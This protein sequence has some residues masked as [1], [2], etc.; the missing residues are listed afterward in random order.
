[1]GITST[2]FRCV[3]SRQDW[4]L[5]FLD[6]DL[7]RGLGERVTTG[8]VILA[9]GQMLRIV[10][11]LVN[12]TVMSRLLP[13]ADFGLF[14]MATTVTAFAMLFMDFGLSSSTIQRK[15]IDQDT[16]SA[17]FYFTLGASIAVMLLS[18]ISAPL[19][20]WFFR[21]ER[22]QWIVF[23]MA[24]TIPVTAVGSQHRALLNRQMRWVAIQAVATVAQI[25]GLLAGVLVASMT[26]LG[27]WALVANAWVIAIVSSLL[28][29]LCMP[30]R[31]G[32]VSDW[33]N[34]RSAL[35]FG[36]NLMG[37][38]IAGWFNRQ[39]DNVLLGWRWGSTEL[40]FYT[41]AYTIY[42]LP[43]TF[44]SRPIASAV[45]PALSRLQNQATRWRS[46]LLQAQAPLYLVAA[47]LTTVLV[48]VSEPLVAVVLGDGWA[49]SG[50]ILAI[51]SASMFAGM[52]TN[53]LGWIYISLGTSNRMF[54]YSLV[55]LPITL[56]GFWLGLPYGPEGIAISVLIV[57]VIFVIPSAVY[58]TRGTPVKAKA[59]LRI[60]FPPI[61]CGVFVLGLLYQFYI[62]SPQ[63]SA[64]LSLMELGALSGGLYLIGA[65][66]LLSLDPAYSTLKSKV[67][68]S[69][70]PLLR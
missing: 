55:R 12:L 52:I 64:L 40:G 51:L 69:L 25:T 42:M 7:R 32:R 50:D 15:T 53:S 48:A 27:Y 1:M 61:L 47:G 30:W 28:T 57:E 54:R 68:R 33:T 22:V 17:I 45:I 8:G 16:L 3:S 11:Q 70:H 20:S 34:A 59:I 4:D 19:S 21:D 31:P 5:K 14:S 35:H 37:S 44:V 24:I 67:W 46:A 26:D 2:W 13:P 66:M 10:L 38:N 18:W 29:W 62:P 9:V 23:A 49:K 6:E 56:V 58:A 41:R 60:G 63:T 36:A 43:L 65:V 39:G